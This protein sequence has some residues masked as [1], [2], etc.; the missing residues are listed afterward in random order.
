MIIFALGLLMCLFGLWMIGGWIMFPFAWKQFE[1]IV[2]D[3]EFPE[4]PTPSK[5][6]AINP[7]PPLFLGLFLFLVVGGAGLLVL[8]TR[9]L[10]RQKALRGS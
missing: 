4:F 6:S 10:R 1:A 9:E 5:L 2:H 7:F 3:R 8:G